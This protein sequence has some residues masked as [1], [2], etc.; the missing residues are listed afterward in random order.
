MPTE[1]VADDASD[2]EDATIVLRAAIGLVQFGIGLA[3][4]SGLRLAG[5]WGPFRLPVR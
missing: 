4:L 3:M 2:K 5:V 1:E